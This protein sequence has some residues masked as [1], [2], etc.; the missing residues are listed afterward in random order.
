MI[1]L[2]I[3]AVILIGWLLSEVVHTV[4]IHLAARFNA[5]YHFHWLNPLCGL[6]FQFI[7]YRFGAE[8]ARGSWLGGVSNRRY[9]LLN[10]QLLRWR[11]CRYTSQ[12]QWYSAWSFGPLHYS[13]EL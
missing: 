9:T 12:A 8:K 6:G 1:A 3:I 11:F 13:R 5:G 4:R 10:F 7:G 2:S